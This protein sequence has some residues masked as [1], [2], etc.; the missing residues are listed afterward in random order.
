MDKI[1]DNKEIVYRF[2]R[3]ALH[4][5]RVFSGGSPASALLKELL[6]ERM[7]AQRREPIAPPR[8]GR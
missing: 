8:E 1:D 3:T 7:L 5:R 2:D 4:V 6:E